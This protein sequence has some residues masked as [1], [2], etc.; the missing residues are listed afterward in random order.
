MN[1][2]NWNRS[3]R[4]LLL[5]WLVTVVSAGFLL[6]AGVLEPLMVLIVG[7]S[8]LGGVSILVGRGPLSVDESSPFPEEAGR[9]TEADDEGSGSADR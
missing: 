5:V 3:T 7:A 9:N 8:L 4:D 6:L 2:D 1:D